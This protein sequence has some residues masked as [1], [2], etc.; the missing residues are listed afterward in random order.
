M[1]IYTSQILLTVILLSIAGIMEAIMDTLAHH[2]EGSIFKELNPDF[3]NPV[4]SGGNKW[5]NGDKTQGERF[6]L[7]STLLVGFTEGWHLAK[8]FR[9]LLLFM[10]VAVFFGWGIFLVTMVTYKI[11][12]TIYY[13]IFKL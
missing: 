10:P 2:F 3:W 13:K 11:S 9:T 4:K 5:K 12:F 1:E 6:F 8:M 7:S